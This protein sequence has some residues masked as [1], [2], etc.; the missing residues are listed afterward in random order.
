MSHAPSAVPRAGLRRRSAFTL[1]ELLVVISI[2]AILAG[3][4]LPAI[5]M[6][7]ESARKSSCGNNQRQIVLAMLVY[8]N[9]N[10]GLWPVR[11]TLD[12]GSFDAAMQPVKALST[13]VGSFEFLAGQTGRDITYK[14]FICPDEISSRPPG[15]AATL[16]YATGTSAWAQSVAGSASN[17]TCPGYAFDWSVPVRAT[18]SRVVTT[19]RG[20]IAKAHH[21]LAMACFGDGHTGTLRQSNGTPVGTT[22]DLLGG[23]AL[24]NVVF[25]NPDA[26]GEDAARTVDDVFD[27]N[28][29]GAMDTPALGST[30]R[31]WVR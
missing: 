7:R 3:M 10:D 27:G 11:P 9:E 18:G 30:T 12:D 16:E 2:I 31:C 17:S 20:V 22:T 29:D 25:A 28:G 13:A 19:D 5:N 24:G 1:I 26:I 4:L 15:G 14:V 8:A 21:K 6:V 23:V